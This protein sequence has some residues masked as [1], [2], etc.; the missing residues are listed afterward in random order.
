MDYNKVVHPGMKVEI[1][2]VLRQKLTDVEKIRKTY[3]TSVYDV[4]EDGRLELYMPMAKGRVVLLAPNSSY[5]LY[6]YVPGAMYKAKARVVD[7]RKDRNFFLVT[8]ELIG[9]IEKNQR[10]EFFRLDC[11]LEMKFRK[12]T[13]N[14]TSQLL[15]KEPI[16]IEEDAEFQ[17]GVMMD[18]SGGGV[19][20]MSPKPYMTNDYVV[21]KFFLNKEYTVLGRVLGARNVPD[22]PGV[23]EY[24]VEYIKLEKAE[25]EEIVRYI[26]EKERQMRKARSNYDIEKKKLD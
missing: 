25:R 6:F 22:R 21:A 12:L 4:Y 20:L 11:A 14:E 19:R 5:D 24:R 1:Q 15:K 10:R 3:E 7:R 18:I 9:D 2:T 8:F 23:T 17:P 16:E 13:V 26:F